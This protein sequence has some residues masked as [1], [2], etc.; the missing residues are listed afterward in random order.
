MGGR[1]R[2]GVEDYRALAVP[3][4]GGIS[5]LIEFQ[6]TADHKRM[7]H[8]F[9]RPSIGGDRQGGGWGHQHDRPPWSAAHQ[10]NPW[11][12]RSPSGSFPDADTPAQCFRRTMPLRSV[13]STDKVRCHPAVVQNARTS[14]A[15]RLDFSTTV[16]F[17]WD[18]NHLPKIKHP[19]DSSSGPLDRRVWRVPGQDVGS[20]GTLT[21]DFWTSNS[22]YV[23]NPVHT[24]RT[25]L[26]R[27]R[28]TRTLKNATAW[29]Q[30][31]RGQEAAGDEGVRSKGW[32]N[33]FQ[34]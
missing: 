32:T 2:Y 6:K 14:L 25:Q 28:H 33:E 19:C 3:A 8:G 11:H 30:A 5:N 15:G 22:G 18:K 1:P 23:A 21:R 13:T 7:L 24:C 16:A 10:H 31:T 34:V 29:P 4:A 20:E 26:Q 9:V 17:Q 27:D 12:G